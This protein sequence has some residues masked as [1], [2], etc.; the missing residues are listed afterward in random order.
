M[1][2]QGPQGMVVAE[3]PVAG[4]PRPYAFPPFRRTRLA[5]GLSVVAVDMP[6]RP[7]LSA[8]L[9]VPGGATDEPAELAGATIL[10]ARALAEGTADHDAVA[11]V[12]AI[13]RLGASLHAEAGWDALSIS[14]DVPAGRFAAALDLVA[15]VAA[16]PTFPDSEVERLREERLND[17]LQ[18]RA[19]PRRRA[20]DAFIDTIYAPT[21]PYRRSSAGTTE[22]V[23]RLDASTCRAE[24]ARRFD[25]ARMSLIVGGDLAGIDV[26]RL[27]NERFGGWVADP[28]TRPP[29]PIDATPAARH[30]QIRVVHRPG[31]VQT[32]IRI[33]HPGAARLIPDFH[34][35]AVMSAVLGGLFNSRLNRKLREEKGYTYGAHAGFDLRRGAGPFAARAPVDTAVT[36]PAILEMLAVIDGIGGGV[37]QVELDEARDYLVGVFPLRFETAGAVVGALSGIVIQGLPDDELARYRPAIQAVTAD[38]VVAAATAHVHPDELAIVLVGD[39]DAFLPDL[40][41][42]GLGP[43]EVERDPVPASPEVGDDEDA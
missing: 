19:D 12:E 11:L 32:E 30:R 29:G 43:I 36:V 4:E 34:A 14:L 21:S 8:A 27:A 35:L 13:E 25:P 10:M 37:S 1:S 6:G 17:I 41:A 20:E 22:T 15:E 5:N 33:G 7:L 23:E 16:R 39:A 24:L 9:V 42:A 31:S 26:E 3:R 38:D 18:A 28:A 2:P 40:E